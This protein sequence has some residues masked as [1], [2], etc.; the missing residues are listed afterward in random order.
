MS[1]GL[2]SVHPGPEVD[3]ASWPNDWWVKPAEFRSLIMGDLAQND[4][5]CGHSKIV[6]HAE[7]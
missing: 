2:Y 6:K 3:T 7:N 1:F 4:G 5:H